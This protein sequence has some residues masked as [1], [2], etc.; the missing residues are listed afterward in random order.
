MCNWQLSC[1]TFTVASVCFLLSLSSLFGSSWDLQYWAAIVSR[2]RSSHES[3]RTTG[4]PRPVSCLL[5]LFCRV[6]PQVF[7]FGYIL[8]WSLLDLDM[9][10]QV[11]MIN[12]VLCQRLPLEAGFPLLA[13]S[14]P[15][16]D[17][18]GW[19]G[20]EVGGKR[21]T[22]SD[23]SMEFCTFC[24]M[25]IGILWPLVRFFH[26]ACSLPRT[27]RECVPRGEF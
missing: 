6:P 8:L 27:Y 19:K 14:E 17:I 18:L 24:T 10:Y 9:G 26:A 1:S 25:R 11:Y 21:T 13:F 12:E 22:Q 7:P 20:Q 16:F 4:D 5:H 23:A 2:S 15:T 3:V